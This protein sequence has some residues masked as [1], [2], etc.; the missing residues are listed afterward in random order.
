M[1]F[2]NVAQLFRHFIFSQHFRP[3]T[4]MR[5]NDFLA[6][7]RIDPVMRIFHI[8]LVFDKIARSFR[9]AD[10]VVKGTDTA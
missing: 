4:G 3:V 6:Q 2:R 5:D 1:L 10:I 8:S 7:G 9:L